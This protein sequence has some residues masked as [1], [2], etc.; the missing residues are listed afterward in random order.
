[1]RPDLVRL[2][3][4]RHAVAVLVDGSAVAVSGDEL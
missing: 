4:A 3:G 1:M 2:S